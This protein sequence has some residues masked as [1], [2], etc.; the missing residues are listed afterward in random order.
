MTV[1]GFVLV[2]VPRAG[3][4]SL[5]RYLGQHPQVSLSDIKEIN[6]LSYPGEEL[7][8]TRYPWLR[9]PIRTIEEYGQL[10]AGGP[11]RVGVD[12]SASCF[13][14][15]VAIDRIR[16]FVPDARLFV[17]LRDPVARAWSAYLNRVDKRYESRSP[18]EALVRGELAVENGF[19]SERLEAFRTEFGPD[20]VRAWLFE[21]L[22]NRPHETVRQIF[23]Y[24]GVDPAAPVDLTA[25]HNRSGVARSTAVHR[26][27]P[28]QQGRRQ[29]VAILPGP[30]RRAAQRLRRLN[31]A[32][33]PKPPVDVATRLRELYRDDIK[34]LEQTLGRDLQ[35]WLAG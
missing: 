8:R 2:G 23:E 24:L 27:L 9:F 4:T 22:T 18:A 35:S 26:L 11:G 21:D 33:A 6:F 14:S 20:R 28:S 3:T 19:Y 13:R 15:P 32:P 1:P 7:A 12:F 31:Q 16:R 17:L 25:V 5:Y 30:A 29:L 10:F 34:R